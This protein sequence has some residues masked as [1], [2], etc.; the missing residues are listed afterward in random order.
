MLVTCCTHGGLS[1]SSKCHRG[2]HAWPCPGTNQ[3]SGFQGAES[4]QELAPL[5]ILRL[6]LV[7]VKV[8]HETLGVAKDAQAGV[9]RSVEQQLAFVHLNSHKVIIKVVVRTKDGLAI[10]SLSLSSSLLRTSFS[11]SARRRRFSIVF[12]SAYRGLFRSPS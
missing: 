11:K 4:V 3:R 5:S 7:A 12:P 6:H 2:P 8:V 10:R 9:H 1:G